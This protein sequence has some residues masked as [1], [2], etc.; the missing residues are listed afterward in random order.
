LHLHDRG[1]DDRR[2][3]RAKA[4]PHRTGTTAQTNARGLHSLHSEQ[5]LVAKR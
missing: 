4:Q 2:G 5:L 3:G 1:D